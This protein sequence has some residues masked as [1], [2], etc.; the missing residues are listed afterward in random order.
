MLT[1]DKG[2]TFGFLKLLYN[3]ELSSNCNILLGVKPRGDA[4]PKIISSE[5]TVLDKD[6]YDLIVTGD[7]S[8]FIPTLVFIGE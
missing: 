5:N 7:T 8:N 2:S 1:V 6:E 3:A 4:S